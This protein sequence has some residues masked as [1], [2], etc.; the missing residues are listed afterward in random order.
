VDTG[1]FQIL[2]PALASLNPIPFDIFA[3]HPYPSGDYR[4]GGPNT[5]ILVDPLD[6][7]PFEQPT[8]L[9]KFYNQLASIG[10][11]DRPVWI[12]EIG[13]NR[14]KD[15]TSQDTLGCSLINQTMV[16]GGE[17]GLYLYRGFDFLFK[18]TAWASGA[19][20]VKKVFW[21]QYID[22][23]R[24]VP[25]SDC[26]TAS[27]R[28]SSWYGSDS[29]Q[30]GQP[31]TPH[32]LVDWW[33]GLYSGTDATTPLPVPHFSQ[34]LFRQY[35][36]TNAVVSCLPYAIYAPLVAAPNLMATAAESP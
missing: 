21:Y 11:A 3:I 22:V 6:Y 15:S 18:Q 31:A 4:V 17:Q 36:A 29:A 7:L 10:F 32:R 19:A 25:E 33:F 26:V 34:C 14:A 9:S 12:T 5:P 35:P 2:I 1:Y 13:W 28:A 30:Y 23:G 27:Q 24:S 8:I 16:S 20:S